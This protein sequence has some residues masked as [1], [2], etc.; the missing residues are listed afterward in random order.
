MARGM[1]EAMRTKAMTMIKENIA[2][3][4][5]ASEM[6]NET[7]CVSGIDGEHVPAEK[8]VPDVK[9]YISE[10]IYDPEAIYDSEI[11]N[12]PGFALVLSWLAQKWH[13]RCLKLAPGDNKNLEQYLTKDQQ[14]AC[15][16]SA[17]AELIREITQGG[18]LN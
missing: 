3:L 8:I 6:S 14:E 17:A 7:G 9:K 16:D 13:R 4:K 10:T 1:G 2:L 12:T 18:P 11:W 15:L 5:E